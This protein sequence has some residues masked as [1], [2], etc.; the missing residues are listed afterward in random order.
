MAELVSRTYSQ[1][2][3]DVAF[4]DNRLNEV[5]QEFDFVAGVLKDY[6]D[7][8]SILKSPKVSLD[9]KKAIIV[10]TFQSQISE[11]L[12][13][14]LKI[15]VD[16]KRVSEILEIKESF[17]QRIVEHDNVAYAT[18]ESVVPLDDA[19][20]ESIKL[21]LKQ[22]TGKNVEIDTHINKELLGG[23]VVKIGDRI[24]DG[25]VRYKLEGMLESLTQIII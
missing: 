9:E 18:V 19:Q 6:P 14:F 10:E 3:F 7:Y 12:L 17:D 23:V 25:S 13:N 24:I 22:I 2:M 15:I 16:K 20:L 11:P 1:A 5:K 8:F 4:E 21:K